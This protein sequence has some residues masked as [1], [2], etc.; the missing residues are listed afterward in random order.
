[1]SIEQILRETVRKV[2]REELPVALQDIIEKD[3][4]NKN[5]YIPTSEVLKMLNV[6]RS[7]WAAAIRDYSQIQQHVR[8]GNTKSHYWP[9]RLIEAIRD[10][11][12]DLGAG[13]RVYSNGSKS[14]V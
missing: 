3:A 13:E 4:R 5:R 12:N 6:S 10:S 2:L 7:W 9:V 1:M 14:G 11:G 8:K